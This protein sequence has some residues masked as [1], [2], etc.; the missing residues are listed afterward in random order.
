MKSSFI[1]VSLLSVVL[2]DLGYPDY[3]PDT[4]PDSQR[5]LRACRVPDPSLVCDPNAILNDVDNKE[6]KNER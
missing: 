6:G 3:T 5:D 4:Y 2:A 1:I